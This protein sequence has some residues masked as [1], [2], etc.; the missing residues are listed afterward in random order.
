MLGRLAKVLTIDSKPIKS[1]Y[2]L[3]K[4][5]NSLLS[6]SCPSMAAF[7]VLDNITSEFDLNSNW[8][9]RF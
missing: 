3:P 6:P 4:Y 5:A 1:P 8:D 9:L 7:F 2:A